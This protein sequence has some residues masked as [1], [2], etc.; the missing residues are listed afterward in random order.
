MADIVVSVQQKRRSSIERFRRIQS[1]NPVRINYTDFV[2]AD[3][4]TFSQIK[5]VDKGLFILLP[6]SWF[7]MTSSRFK[8][9][10]FLM[11]FLFNVNNSSLIRLYF[12]SHIGG[13]KNADQPIFRET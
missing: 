2:A 5:L 12:G 3:L 7:A 10:A 9:K 11:I 4:Y 8:F 13:Q 1:G 6:N